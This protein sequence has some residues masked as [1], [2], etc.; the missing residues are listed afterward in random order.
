MRLAAVVM[1]LL[2]LIGLSCEACSGKH[3]SHGV[4]NGNVVK[5]ANEGWF[6]K[7][8]EVEIIRGGMNTGSGSF[9]V[10]PF[11]ATVTNQN[12]LNKLQWA[13]DQQKEVVI[14]YDE[15]FFT[16]FSSECDG[17]DEHCSYV[18]SVEVKP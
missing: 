3:T 18:S 17:E 2:L 7:T 12:D 4:R 11:Y 16:P 10:K 1:I 9:G 13:F 6:W 15:Y 8:S 14:T 5:L